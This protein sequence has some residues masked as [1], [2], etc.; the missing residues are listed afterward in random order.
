MLGLPLLTVVAYRIG[1]YHGSDRLARQVAFTLT[2]SVGELDG[3][4]LGIT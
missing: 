2:A 3:F 4:D 1:G